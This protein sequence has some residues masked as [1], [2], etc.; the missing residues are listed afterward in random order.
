MLRKILVAY[1][2]S[3]P[4][5]HAFSYALELVKHC[6]P[7]APEIIVVAVVQLPEPADIVELDAM[8]DSAT[9]HY[10]ALFKELED[11]AKAL[12]VEIKTEVVVGHPADQV[13]RYAKEH[14]IDMIFAGQTGKSKIETWLMGSVS[15]RIVTYAHCPVTI[16]KQRKA[17]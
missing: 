12:H 7:C 3:E 16:V 10:Q 11:K 14:D 13:I 8:I 15:R 5:L 6:S 4:S 1:D 17:C 2:G 9:E